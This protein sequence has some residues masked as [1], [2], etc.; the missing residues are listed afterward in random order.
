MKKLL[1]AASTLGL[2][3]T[4]TCAHRSAGY[5]AAGYA[6]A[7]CSFSE[8]CDGSDRYP[9][10][11]VF[12]QA[13]PA[14]PARLQ[15]VQG[16]R[17]PSPR[18]LPSRGDSTIGPEPGTGSSSSSASTPA[19]LPP[20]RLRRARPG[21]PRLASSGGT[22]SSRPE[23]TDHR[24]AAAALF[25]G[26]SVLWRRRSGGDRTAREALT[27]RVFEAAALSER[28]GTEVAIF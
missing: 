16:P 9:Y 21:D 26:Q 18:T 4:A 3:L 17:R 13:A 8:D 10:S 19:S 28:V 23:L 22:H 15:V 11:C 14:V 25:E 20:T 1:L 6:P 12:Y 27:C 7:E 5:A 2:L 24:A